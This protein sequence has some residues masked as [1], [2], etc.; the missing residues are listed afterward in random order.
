G[1]RGRVVSGGRGRTRATTAAAAP[2]VLA[3]T[4]PT[5]ATI[6]AAAAPVASTAPATVTTPTATTTLPTAPAAQKP[7]GKLSS[8]VSFLLQPPA[9]STPPPVMSSQPPQFQVTPDTPA[10]SNDQN[11]YSGNR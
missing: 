8:A 1:V 7:P 9:G 2:G 11:F 5:T 10:A 3:P 4:A 6:P